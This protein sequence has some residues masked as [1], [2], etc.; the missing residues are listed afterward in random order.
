M[1]SVKKIKDLTFADLEK[2]FNCPP[3]A[4][5]EGTSFN[6]GTSNPAQGCQSLKLKLK[7]ELY[8]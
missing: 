4:L 3:E 5:A 7:L 2:S 1:A 8:F 6:F